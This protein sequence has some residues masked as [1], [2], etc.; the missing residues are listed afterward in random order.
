MKFALDTPNCRCWLW[1]ALAALM[2]LPLASASGQ[3][4][5]YGQFPST[6]PIVFSYDSQ[7]TRLFAEDPD[8]SL[9]YNLQINGLTAFT[10]YS[11][12]GFW[13]IPASGNSV[14][15][16]QPYLPNSQAVLVIPLSAG[17]QIG[18]DAAG[19]RW[20]TNILGGEILA[21]ARD[22]GTIGDGGGFITDG[23]FVGIDKAYI[24]LQFQ[25]NGQTNYGWVSAGAP[26][27]GINGG[28]I[29]EYAYETQPN[30]PILAG[31]VPLTPLGMP[32]IVRPGNLRLNWQ[33]QINKAYQVQFQE[34][35]DSLFWTNLD[36]TIIATA[37]NTSADVPMVGAARFYR[38]IQ[39]Q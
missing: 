25:Q 6:Q 27:V 26:V 7:G 14:I 28:W 38:V 24:G 15:A 20:L 8:H 33:S 22:G 18:R 9:T 35:L 31:A 39:V 16:V 37:T 10:F 5:V 36:L 23:Y 13:I 11:G 30:T 3:G 2:A 29:Y 1:P 32:Q 21:S 17:V 34:Q 12:S 19:Y 4:I